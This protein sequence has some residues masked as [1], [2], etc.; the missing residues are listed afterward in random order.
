LMGLAAN[1]IARLLERRKW[2]SY[3]GLAIVVYVAVKMIWE[4]GHAVIA[5][6][7]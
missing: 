2:I 4:G 1:L 6:F 3:I 7:S 5:A